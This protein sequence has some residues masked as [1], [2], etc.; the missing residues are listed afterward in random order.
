MSHETFFRRHAAAITAQIWTMSLNGSLKTFDCTNRGL[1][2]RTGMK[3]LKP[4]SRHFSSLDL[5]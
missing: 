2:F 1:K 4:C 5:R 3:A